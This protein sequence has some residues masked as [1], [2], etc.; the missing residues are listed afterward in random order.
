MVKILFLLSLFFSSIASAISVSKDNYDLAYFGQDAKVIPKRS[1]F[2][3]HLYV[4]LTDEDMQALWKEFNKDPDKKSW[5]VKGFALVNEETAKCIVVIPPPSSWDDRETLAIL[6]H[7]ILHCTGA[8][9][10]K[11]LDAN[12]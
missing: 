1:D 7:E 10:P 5:H 12:Q 8:V 3:V 6:G 4:A 2:T 11:P 9:H